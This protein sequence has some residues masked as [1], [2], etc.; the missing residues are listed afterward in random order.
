LRT[1]FPSASLWLLIL[2]GA[3]SVVLGPLLIVLP[4]EGALALVWLIAA[5]ALVSGVLLLVLAF[6]LRGI[7]QEPDAATVPPVA[8]ASPAP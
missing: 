8:G 4:G 7:K 6:R 2:A 3:L 1:A 5:Y